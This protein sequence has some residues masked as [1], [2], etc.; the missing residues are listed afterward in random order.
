MSIGI[1]VNVHDGLVMAADSASTLSVLA[2]GQPK[3]VPINVYN[4]ANKIVNLYKGEPIGCVAYGSGSIG[5]ASVSTLLKDFR[6]RLTDGFESTFDRTSYTMEGV[7][8][9]LTSFL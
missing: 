9:A 7:A 6:T 3:S 1:L 8:S 2:Q 5:S 4:N